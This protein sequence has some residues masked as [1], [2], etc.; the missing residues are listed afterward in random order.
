M[1]NSNS[2]N[3]YDF[4][5]FTKDFLSS[6]V[7]FLVAIPLCL[8]IA[9]AS[10]MSPTSG[11]ISGIIGG[12]IVGFF[13]GCPLQVSGPAAG[14][15][16]V[17]WGIINKHGIE[18]LGAII[19][20]A[21]IL[22]I[23]FGYLK[24]GLWFRAVTPSVVYGMLSGIGI[25]IFSAQFHVM[26]DDLPRKTGIENIISIPDSIFKGL[27]PMD[28]TAHHLAGLIGLITISTI[29]LWGLLPERFNIIPAPIIAV[30]ISSLVSNFLE[31]PIKYV[32]LPDNLF[33]DI[34]FLPISK[35]SSLLN[36]ETTISV[37]ALT[38]IASAETL[39]TVTAV[40][41]MKPG[42][43]TNYN[44]EIISQ[45]IGNTIAGVLGILPITGVIVR[46][47]ANV[48]AGAVTRLSTMLHGIWILIF[49]LVLPHILE[50]I[51]ICSLAA[52]LVY[53]GYKL[54][55][56]KIV[57]ELIKYGRIE[58]VIFIVT[59]L[60]IICISLLEGIL[61]GLLLSFGKLIY[62]L[63][64]IEIKKSFDEEK[65]L[66]MVSIIGNATFA[67]LPVIASEFESLP[68]GKEV[69]INI[70]ELSYIDHACIEFLS[71]WDKSYTKD[72]GRVVLEWNELTSIA[73]GNNNK[74]LTATKA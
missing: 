56:F 65:K 2:I 52:V 57:K 31:Y 42:L 51:P 15:V 58:A 62:Q 12:I 45:G 67:N 47:A 29:I 44:K 10:G 34:H 72:N 22:Q 66:I 64:Y 4:N 74:K 43:K 38:F 46:S 19:F 60:G 14:L 73:A 25:L 55:N 41:Q 53:T 63:A 5:I 71:N 18:H 16:A 48:H 11:L 61:I 35:F 36:W 24:L 7:V 59:I 39:L 30:I 33:S 26:F 40:S 70:K 9:I 68:R 27:F 17:V 28:G 32:S 3:K 21:G 13:S 49:V 1:F 50:K 8:G 6:I 20:A 37:L 54:F 23:I 69:H